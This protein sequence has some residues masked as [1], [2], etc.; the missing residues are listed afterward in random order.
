VF[1]G[2]AAGA[3]GNFT[4]SG[5]IN[6]AA[7]EFRRT[8]YTVYAQDEWEVT[9]RLDVLAG[10]RIDWFDGGAPR[11]NPNFERRYGFSNATPFSRLDAAILPRFAFTYDFENEGFVSDT[12]V[13]GGIGIF[14]GGDPVVYFSNAFSNNGF[15][16]GFGQTGVAGCGPVGTRID[17]VQNGQFSG[18][19]ACVRTNGG[20]QS[21]RGLAD[22]QSTDPNFKAPSVLRANLG[23]VTQFGTGNGGIFDNWRLNLDYIYSRFRDPLNFVDLSQTPDI[24]RANGGF[25][26]DGRPIYAAIDPTAAGCNARLIGTGGTPPV[27]T[28]VTAPCFATSRDDE[29]QLTNGPSYESHVASIILSK[30]FRGFTEGGNVR[31]NLGYAFTD[32]KNNR[33]NASSTATSSYDIVAAFDR[34]N[35]AIATSEFQTRHNISTALNFRE[36]FFGDYNTSFGFV[37]VARS[38]RPYSLTFNNGGVFN[39]SAS[40][41]DNALLYIPTGV[42]DPNVSP[43]VFNAA[44]VRTGGSDPAAVQAL[45]NYAG[46]LD[47]ARGF[48]GRSIVRN[49]CRNDWFYDLDLRFSQQ[50][51]GPGRLF[52]VED[53]VELFAD[54]DNFLN[55]L[56]SGWNV[57]RNRDYAVAVVDGG[58]DAQGRYVITNFN[59]DDEEIVRTSSSVWRIQV[60]LRYEF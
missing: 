6:E 50:L 21:A 47:C 34:Q 32:A 39:D 17:V 52:G 7:A 23:L 49:T 16:T 31:F 46:N 35:P 59:P 26:T 3:Y 44:G 54:F 18:V 33:F 43:A 29:I 58:V 48:T 13:R 22:T 15:S 25:T 2:Q 27:Y 51:P 41:V 19:P 10:V 14:S 42:N 45:V 30:N 37:F 60:G 38:G 56:D 40:G 5:D 53:R 28:N 11:R 8:I 20:T 57:F 9:P 24:R 55:L 12:Q 4:A 1:A 36:K